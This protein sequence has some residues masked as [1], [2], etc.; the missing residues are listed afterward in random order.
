[1]EKLIFL[2]TRYIEFDDKND[3]GQK[4]KGYWVDFLSKEV[5]ESSDKWKILTEQQFVNKTD[6]EILEKIRQLVPGQYFNFE[7]SMVGR[8]SVILTDIIPGELAVD[9]NLI[10]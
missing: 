6:V 5:D 9:F 8:K 7:F 1:M 3:P 4:V 2:R 10:L